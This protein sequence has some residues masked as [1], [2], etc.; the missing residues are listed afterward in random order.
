MEVVR[1]IFYYVFSKHNIIDKISVV[2][3][4]SICCAFCMLCIVHTVDC[5]FY[6]LY[7]LCFVYK[8]YLT[9]NPMQYILNPMQHILYPMK[10]II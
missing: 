10:Y 4:N 9:A 5:T 7:T 6:A 2:F 1:I 3:Q 8:V